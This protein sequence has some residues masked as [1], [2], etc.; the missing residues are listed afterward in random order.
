MAQFLSDADLGIGGPQ[1]LND[2]DMGITVPKA[3]NP[4]AIGGIGSEIS[5]AFTENLDALKSSYTDQRLGE[6]LHNMAVMGNGLLGIPGMLSSPITGAARA[7]IGRAFE[8]MTPDMSDEL[9]Q[10]LGV[11]DPRAAADLAMSGVA[12]RGYSS[13][14]PRTVPAPAPAAIE[15]KQ[16]AKDVWNSPAI[17][18]IEIPPSDVA[19][20][21]E[22]T[23][24]SLLNE[25]FRPT[26]NSA[27]GTLAEID[28]MYPGNIPSVSVD[29]LRAARKALS[30]NAKQIGPDFKPTEDAAAATRAM[31]ELDDFLDGLSPDLKTANANYRAGKSGELLD[32][33]TMKADRRAAKTGSG[34]NMENTM[35]QEVDKIPDR[36]LTPELRALKDQIVLGDKSRNALRTAGKLGVDGGLSLMLHSGVAIGTG[37]STLPITVSGTLARK[38]GEILTRRQI[39]QL[40]A[41][42]RN[43]SPLA[44]SAPPVAL[45]TPHPLLGVP[46]SNLSLAQMLGMMR[47]YPALMP[48][49]AEDQQ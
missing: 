30:K 42:I 24:S 36:G 38:L 28:R 3:A 1:L 35:R 32:Y 29:D 33:R 26:P 11:P 18:S 48:A 20:L 27:P 6:P 25:G 49:R 16:A 44:R 2:A 21:A 4:N 10:K 8:A 7:T 15:L 12:P 46:A 39:S 37:G 45:P 40:N 41:G 19:R 22:K 34:M 13:V 14:G 31:R 9:R 23:E 43:N 17:K 5:R 47:P